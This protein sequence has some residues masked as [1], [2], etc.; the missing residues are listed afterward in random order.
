MPYGPHIAPHDD[1]STYRESATLLGHSGPVLAVRFTRD[2]SYCMSTGKDRTIRLWNPHKQR[3]IA[4]YTGHGH[5]V[6]DVSINAD[7]STFISCGGDKQVFMWDVTHARVIRKF[8]GHDSDVNTVSYSENCSICVSGGY[9]QSVKVWDC[10]SRSIDPIQTMKVFHDSVMSVAFLQSGDIVAGSVDG[11]VR[12]FDCRKGAMITDLVHH[13][14][15]CVTPSQD[16]RYIVAACMDGCV[17][18]LD[19][20]SGQ[21]LGSFRGHAHAYSKLDA[22]LSSDESQIIGCSEDGRI[23]FWD[24]LGGN[25]VQ[26]LKGH[27]SAVTSVTLSQDLDLLSSSADGSIKMWT[28]SS[29]VR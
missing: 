15:T 24:I 9:D 20:Q 21:L 6:R 26:T 2:G 27:V 5:D 1:A 12:R 16:N 28:V 4:V 8:R 25:I 18:L 7:N 13:P 22:I 14:V 23:L 3:E 11:T 17:R 19:R 10:R 29:V